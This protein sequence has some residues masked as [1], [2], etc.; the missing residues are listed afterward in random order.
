MENWYVDLIWY[1][2]VWVVILALAFWI[3]KGTIDRF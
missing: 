1:I 3:V 2:I